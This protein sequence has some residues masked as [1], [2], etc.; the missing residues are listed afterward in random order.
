MLNNFDFSSQESLN[1][2]FNLIKSIF[3]KERNSYE[4]SIMSLK[5]KIIE[6]EQ[7]LIKANKEKMKY[8]AKISSLKR[9]LN[10][11]SKTVSK[12]EESDYDTKKGNKELEKTEI[13]INM[14]NFK[15]NTNNNIK[16]RNNGKANSFRKRTKYTCNINRSASD[17]FNHNSRT[18][19]L[20]KNDKK[21][22]SSRIKSGL[23]NVQQTEDKI[24]SKQNNVNN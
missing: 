5:N 15:N 3:D 10:S 22:L 17:N 16:Y 13:I 11:I 14:E 1:D 24:K 4:K 9:K 21:A 12:L 23:L 18:H 19:D 20:Q 2:A 7:A 8:Q 6:L